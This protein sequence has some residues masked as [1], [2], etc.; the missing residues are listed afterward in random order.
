LGQIYSAKCR[1]R[2]ADLPKAL[3]FGSYAGR[4]KAELNSPRAAEVERYWLEQFTDPAPLLNLPVDHARP[5]VKSFGGS[6][7]RKKMDRS[8][9]EAI[10]RAGAQRGAT[11]FT[12]LL[13]GFE[14][15]LFRLTGQDDIVVG[16][17]AAAQSL[18]DG[19]TLVGHCVNFLPIRSRTT[20]GE[21]FEELLSKTKRG[22][23]DAYDHQQ[24]TYGTLVRKLGLKRDPSRLPLIE[25]QFN[26][27]RV[28]SGAVFD[29]LAVE[30]DPNPKRAV[31]F[32]L[33]FNVVESA[34]GL[35]IDC[36]YNAVLFE[37]ETIERW[38]Q[39]YQNLLCASAQN[40]GEAVTLLPLLSE[41]ERDLLVYGMNQTAAE[42]PACCVHDLVRQQAL[43]T[44]DSIAAVF[45]RRSLTYREL[46]ERSNQLARYLVRFGVGPESKVA[47]CLN[48]SL[49]MLEALLAVLHCGAT[50]VP[51]DPAL[52]RERVQYIL[53]EAEV[54]ALL[55]ESSEAARLAGLSPALI[56]VD[57]DAAGI[58]AE[59]VAPL[60]GAAVPEDLAYIIYTSGS[61]GKPKGVEVSHRAVVNFLWSMRERPGITSEDRLLAVTTLS[62][63][64]AGLELFLPLIAGAR[65]VIASRD[66]TTDGRMLRDLIRDCGITLMQATPATWRLLL[67]ADWTPGPQM[68]ML[69][70]GEALPR[71]LADQLLVGNGELWNMY[72]PTE[73]TIWSAVSRVERGA[74][75][76]LIG[77]PIANTQFYVLDQHRQVQPLGVPGELY[78]AGDGVARGYFAKPQLTA[79]KFLPD[80]FLLSRNPAARM[81]RTGDLVRLLPVGEIEFLGRLDHQVKIRGFRIELG[82]I[83]S[84]LRSYPEVLEAVVT[85]VGQGEAKSLVAYYAAARA[86]RKEDLQS[87]AANSLPAYM[88]PSLFVHLSEMPR[89]PNGKIERKRLPAPD[90]ARLEE[91]RAFC[92]PRNE[93]EEKLAAICSEVLMIDKI[94]IDD[95]LFEL[96]A[97]SIQIFRIVAR[98]ERLGL[99][100][101][102]R[103]ILGKPTIAGMS[104]CISAARNG[105]VVAHRSPIMPVPRQ[106]RPL[107]ARGPESNLSRT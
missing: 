45:E 70:G 101:T 74:G 94:G 3:A 61:T 105:T 32:D 21:S 80:P 47:I 107:T 54:K 35:T 69:S 63:D 87:F 86:L 18:L 30:V 39:Y 55:A 67:E 44:P 43:R 96:G 34:E 64:I 90:F 1:G 19:E 52:P 36:D 22:V 50:Y 16:V 99:A 13:T 79:E 10:K 97:D 7:I 62:F 40:M 48:R 26:L 73:T 20:P 12:R 65:V 28:A 15:L 84:V 88:V 93:Q 6:T 106:R 102:A 27:E 71:P 56:C 24:Y 91:E 81:Y 68:K 53:E 83:E 85:V 42:Y 38:L 17:P 104:A 77:P 72:G 78:I 82:E 37:P 29:G 46:D 60:P 58:A 98:A 59:S 9:Y 75:P 100:L 103:Q 89:T 33:F 14:V 8:A 92:A 41:D 57:T 76:V 23:L 66:A 51:L 11:L 4:Q 25:I 5:A 2:A 95:N 31:N 49:E